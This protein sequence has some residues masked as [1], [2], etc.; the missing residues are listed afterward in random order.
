MS[1]LGKRKTYVNQWMSRN[2]GKY[3]GAWGPSTG[4]RYRS[5]RRVFRRRGPYRTG[6]FYGAS[7]RPR[8]ERKVVDVATYE[9]GCNTTGSVTLLNGCATGTDMTERI[10]RM[11]KTVSVQVRGYITTDAA[12]DATVG[13]LARVM[14]VEDSQTNGVAPTITDILQTAT[15]LSFMNLNNRER[16]KVH[17]DLIVNI[18]PRVVTATQAVAGDKSTEVVN[19]Y[20]KV[21]IPV[22]FEGTGA[23]SASISSGGLYLV[24]IGNVAAGT[25]D[26]SA[27]LCCRTRFV[28]G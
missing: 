1:L 12:S 6:G 27:F 15:S 3:R 25:N 9:Y 4:T 2:A 24:T 19:W 14:V 8:M 28:D 11:V 23:T 21:N 17:Y 26:C 16:F 5:A 10:G 20:K 18:G 22:T 13:Q 7:V